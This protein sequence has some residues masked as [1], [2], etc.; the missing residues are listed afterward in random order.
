MNEPFYRFR[1]A[2]GNDEPTTAELLIF[3]AIGNWTDM[4]EVSAKSFAADLAKLP[5]SVK[6]LD[7]HINSPGGSVAEAQ[8][9]YSRLADHRSDKHVY[10]DGIAASAASLIAMVGHKIYMRAN[11]NM[12]IHNPMGI[13]MGDEDEMDKMK[14]ALASIKETMINVYARKT[15]LERSELSDLLNAETWLT[16]QQAVDKGFA[17][18]VRGVVKAAA[19]LG[20]KRVIINGLTFDLS[21]FNYHN[22]PAFEDA[23]TTEKPM[24]KPKASTEHEESE[25]DK[26]KNKEKKETPAAPPPPANEPAAP[27]VAATAAAEA[28]YDKGVKAERD[29]VQA[30]QKLDRA[31]THDIVVKAISEGKQPSDIFEACLEAMD[32]AQAQS[33]RRTDASALSHIP[34]SDGADDNNSFGTVLKKKVQARLQARGG[35]RRITHSRN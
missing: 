23:S 31:A 14:A 6:R 21:K 7:I 22:V 4:G 34:P 8:G 24:S 28:D 16:P 19:S 25:N 1:A 13:A 30:L 10:I 20:D 29:R 33:N 17:D 9:I 26:D 2:A 18:E 27:P 11:A 5:T 32:K 15:K 12:M 3:D 35:T